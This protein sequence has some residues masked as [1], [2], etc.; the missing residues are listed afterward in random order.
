M[1]K[2][3]NITSI[4]PTPENHSYRSRL[5]NKN[6]LINKAI[7]FFIQLINKPKRVMI[8][9]KRRFPDLWKEVN[10]KKF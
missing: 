5:Y 2:K 3:Q 6:L 7:G 4:S 9:L 10:R 1:K 8:E